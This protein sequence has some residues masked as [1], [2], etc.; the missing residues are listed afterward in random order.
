MLVGKPLGQ[1]SFGR[2]GRRFSLERPRGRGGGCTWL[3]IFGFQLLGVSTLWVLPPA[4]Q[5]HTEVTCE[6]SMRKAPVSTT[7]AELV[8]S[9]LQ[10]H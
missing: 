10:N 4:L 2:S 1:R 7:A 5:T 3:T 6:G 9:L 8:R